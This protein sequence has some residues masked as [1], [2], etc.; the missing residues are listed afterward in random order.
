MKSLTNEKPVVY[1]PK[2]LDDIA[3]KLP[4]AAVAEVEFVEVVERGGPGS[5]FAGHAGRPGERGGSAPGGGARRGREATRVLR[6]N[7]AVQTPAEYGMKENYGSAWM[8]SQG[9]IY[10]LGGRHHLDALMKL[11]NESGRDEGLLSD[12]VSS[13][14]MFRKAMS[15][16]GMLRLSRGV[17]GVSVDFVPG[18][19]TG[20]QI[21]ELRALADVLATGERALMLAPEVP[22]RENDDTWREELSRERREA[23]RLI[24]YGPFPKRE[25]GWGMA[26]VGR[27]GPGSGHFGHE[28]RPG[29]RGGSAP[30]EGGGRSPAML[31]ERRRAHATRIEPGVTR[32]LSGLAGE[33]GGRMHNLG[34][35]IKSHESLARKIETNA[36]A[37]GISL[38]EAAADINDALRYTMVFPADHFVDE[39]AAVQDALAEQGWDQWDTT[40]RNYFA[41]G[42]AYDGYNTVMHNPA[43][44]ERFELQFHTPQTAEIKEEVHAL[45]DQY[46]TSTDRAE[47]ADLWSEMTSFWT[48]EGRPIGWERLRG[49][50]MMEPVAP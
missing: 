24:G 29:E 5:G 22:Y 18:Q 4:Y 21:E 47:R 17:D 11:D 9:T 35:A 26:P 12:E 44:G 25:G 32:L 8:D 23:Y 45:Y 7:Y 48:D 15:E 28:G 13:E 43:T 10:Y 34:R 37:M 19:F 41:P 20:G 39:V 30:G 49:V 46:R 3:A 33:T 16:Y 36:Q 2:Q 6:A 1:S 14:A 38:E 42:D 31:A 50:M 27:G 40:W